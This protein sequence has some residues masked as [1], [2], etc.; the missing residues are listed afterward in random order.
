MSCPLM[1]RREWSHHEEIPKVCLEEVAIPCN[2]ELKKGAVTEDTTGEEAR[3]GGIKTPMHDM[4]P[5][6]QMDASQMV[7]NVEGVR[8]E[9]EVREE[10]SFPTSPSSF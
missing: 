7:S 9:G 3:H 5:E 1:T 10:K 4:Q 2:G 8:G 6:L